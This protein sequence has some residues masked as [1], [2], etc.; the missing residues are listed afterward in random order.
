MRNES[1]VLNGQSLKNKD[2]GSLAREVLCP[3]SA[4]F[5]PPQSDMHMKYLLWVGIVRGL[6]KCI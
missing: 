6:V 3:V 2:R 5:D 1:E 4:H